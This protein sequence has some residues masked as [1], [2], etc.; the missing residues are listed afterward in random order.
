MI[1]T[2]LQWKNAVSCFKSHEFPTETWNYQSRLNADNN[3]HEQCQS[4]QR[5]NN[6][7]AKQLTAQS[8]N[9][10]VNIAC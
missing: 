5:T 8:T 3:L 4:C 10:T 7:E 6:T 2:L 9:T 1:K